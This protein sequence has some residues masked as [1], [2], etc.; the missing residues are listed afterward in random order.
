[1]K[2]S[3]AGIILEIGPTEMEGYFFLT[4][5]KRIYGIYQFNGV[6]S[7]LGVFSGKLNPA[8]GISNLHFLPPYSDME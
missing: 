7:E 2:V 4:Q 3:G 6:E 8:S 1:L 5:K